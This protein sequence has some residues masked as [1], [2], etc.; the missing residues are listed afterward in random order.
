MN[1][2]FSSEHISKTGDLEADL[3][4]RQYKLGTMATFM[5]I[6]NSNPRLKQSEKTRELKISSST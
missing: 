5:H 6:E 3:T 1:N 4:K 2:T